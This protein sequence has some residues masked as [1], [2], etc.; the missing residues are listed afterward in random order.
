M[1]RGGIFTDGFILNCGCLAEAVA[2]SFMWFAT[3]DCYSYDL[4]FTVALSY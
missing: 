4:P 2:K 1:V 3:E